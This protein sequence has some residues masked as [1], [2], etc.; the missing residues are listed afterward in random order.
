MD[1]ELVKRLA[2]A[3]PAKSL[4]AFLRKDFDCVSPALAGEAGRPGPHAGTSRAGRTA[5]RTYAYRG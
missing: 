2:R 1:L 4:A 3:T 5:A